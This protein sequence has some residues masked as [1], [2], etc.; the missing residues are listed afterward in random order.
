MKRISVSPIGM[1]LSLAALTLGTTIG[2]GPSGPQL[3]PVEGQV[4]LS[5]GDVGTL[6]GHS[7]ELALDSDPTKRAFGTIEADGSFS[8]ESL[9]AGSLR[10]GAFPGRYRG[11]IVL[12]DDDSDLR[13]KA[14]E[15]ISPSLLQ[16]ETSN[17]ALE[18]P[19][20]SK[21]VWQISK[22]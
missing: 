2:C 14:L 10:A 21:V 18:V 7:V 6:A 11:R 16:F 1:F 4:V 17:L 5:G 20:Q 19:A 22:S 8:L 9:Y 13:R 12:S 15:A 3:F